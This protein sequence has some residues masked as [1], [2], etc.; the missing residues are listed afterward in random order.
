MYLFL[1]VFLIINLSFVYLSASFFLSCQLISSYGEY[2]LVFGEKK[3]KCLKSSFLT[4]W[5]YEII[6]W[7]DGDRA[8]SKTMEIGPRLIRVIKGGGGIALPEY[9]SLKQGERGKN[10][11]ARIVP[12][13][14]LIFKCV[15]WK[16]FEQ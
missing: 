7:L 1:S 13:P 14:N 5:H 15:P 4:F 2:V 9:E 3:I 11:P 10:R 8:K 16:L 12:P 6:I